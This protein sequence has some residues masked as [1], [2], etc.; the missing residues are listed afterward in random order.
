MLAADGW[1]VALTALECSEIFGPVLAIVPVEDVNEAIDYINSR[2]HPLALYVFTQDAAFKA[3]GMLL[4][5][6]AAIN[7][8]K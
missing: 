5:F 4:V 1:N 6:Q 3:K 2:D 7:T 8:L